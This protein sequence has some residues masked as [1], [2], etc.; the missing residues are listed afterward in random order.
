MNIRQKL[1]IMLLGGAMASLAMPPADSAVV[2]G[3]LDNGLTYYIRHNDVVPGQADFFIGWKVGSV[4]EEENQRGLAHFLEHMCFNGT[5]H[6][7]G[8]TLISWL[9]SN[10][11][12][13]GAN[14]NAYTSTDETV[15]NISKVPV[16]RP[17]MVDSCLLI[18]RDWSRGLTLDPG[19]IDKERG[20]IENEWRHRSSATN[21]MLEKALPEVYPGSRYGERMPIGLMEVVRN[22]TPGDLRAYYD[23][24]YYPVN[25][26]VIV[27]GDIDPAYVETRI[28]TMFSDIAVPDGIGASPVYNVAAN[29]RI[30]VSVQRDKEQ[31]V[32][33]VQLYFKHPAAE[34]DNVSRAD[35]RRGLVSELMTSMLAHRFDEAEQSDDCPHTYLGIGDMKYLMSRPVDALTFKGVVRTGR[36]AD[37]MTLWTREIRRAYDHGF[38][39]GELDLAKRELRQSLVTEKKKAPRTSNTEYARR[40]ARHFIDGGNLMSV[41]DRIALELEIADSITPDEAAA[42]LREIVTPDGHNTVILAYQPDRSDIV[43]VEP[44]VLEAAFSAG[45]SSQTEPYTDKAVGEALLAREPLAGTIVSADSIAGLG[46]KVYTLSNGIRVLAK[47]TDYV[48]GQI[49][50]RGVGPGGLSQEYAE[51]I[52]PTMKMINDVV[53]VSAFGDY[54]ATDLKNLLTGRNVNAT[55]SVSNTEETVEAAT[56]ADNMTDAFRLIYLKSTGLRPDPKA[57]G[58]WRQQARNRLRNIFSNP[59]QVMGDSI[60]RNI[61][62]HHPLGAKETVATIDS[63]D[64]DL[65]VTL[66]KNRFADM[67]DFTFYVAGDFDTDSLES[68]LGRYIAT[69]PTNGRIERPRDIGYRYIQG[70][71]TIEFDCAMETPLAVVYSFLNGE[72]E[73][74][75][76]DVMMASIFGNILKTRLL[77]DIREER[78]WTYSVRTHASVSAGMNGDD[79]ARLMMPVYIKAEP[80]HE[81]EVAEIVRATVA[82]LAQNGATAAE[83]EKVRENLIKNYD[84]NSR[85]NAYWLH[86][87]KNIVKFNQ[88][89]HSGFNDVVGGITP[90]T[91]RDFTRRYVV[92]AGLTQIIMHP[93]KN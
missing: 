65:A 17:T 53:A 71:N 69:L 1:T 8:N 41:D 91:L 28:K 86:V 33:L 15:Y 59:V 74:T 63:V 49:Y 20:V 11:V 21:R 61:Y 3:R 39:P 34:G 10:G 14:L 90:G 78:G 50:V 24:W 92:P 81:N 16:S 70:D 76:P 32:E 25:E 27:V 60:H 26:A 48:P 40:Y 67:A 89:M 79:P 57:F 75:L 82:D 4:N 80:G 2:T 56:D 36:A 31:N 35:I 7:P 46:I 72:C 52:A 73:F 5:E 64:Y 6:F 68:C 77:N 30:C 93:A 62:S 51:A 19:E 43:R 58:R 13:F 45:I 37:A 44:A 88:D 85:D 54:S 18:L 42:Y 66:F 38:C 29:D 9:E 87:M 12:R 83:L 84:D 47:K 23:R 55:I 22:F